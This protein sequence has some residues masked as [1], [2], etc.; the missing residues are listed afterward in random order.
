[1]FAVESKEIGNLVNR[2]FLA[3]DSFFT[4]E[5]INDRGGK[6]IIQVMEISF[7]GAGSVYI[8]ESFHFLFGDI[9]SPGSE[10]GIGANGVHLHVHCIFHLVVVFNQF[11]RFS[12]A[13]A[14]RR[15]PE[16]KNCIGSRDG[17]HGDQLIV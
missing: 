17:M 1:M 2:N 7:G 6:N 15:V 4:V 16:I 5:N 14:A 8:N 12:F 3:Y 10:I 13:M 9:I 11:R